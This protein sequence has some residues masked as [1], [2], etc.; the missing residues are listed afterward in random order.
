MIAKY[1]RELCRDVSAQWKDYIKSGAWLCPGGGAHTWVPGEGDTWRC[2]KC[3]ATR[4][5]PCPEYIWNDKSGFDTIL[6]GRG[7]FYSFHRQLVP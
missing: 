3:P 5:F 2:T 1:P 4:A 7:I 6:E